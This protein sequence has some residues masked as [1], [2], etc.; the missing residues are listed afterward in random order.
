MPLTQ[1]QRKKL[2]EYLSGIEAENNE[3]FIR[4]LIEK[5]SKDFK[6]TVRDIT[7]MNNVTFLPLVFSEYPTTTRQE[8]IEKIIDKVSFQ[9]PAE[10]SGHN[11]KSS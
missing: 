1:E 6:R 4:Y 5:G 9:L 10:D 11:K 8:F 7:G 2:S 3:D